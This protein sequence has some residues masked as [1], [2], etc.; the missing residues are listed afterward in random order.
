MGLL[1]SYMAIAIANLK[2]HLERPAFL[3]T[4]TFDQLAAFAVVQL[5]TAQARICA[6][7]RVAGTVLCA[8]SHDERRRGDAECDFRGG[9]LERALAFGGVRRRST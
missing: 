2:S 7:F 1:G 5:A 6:V 3:L 4:D 8:V 9:F